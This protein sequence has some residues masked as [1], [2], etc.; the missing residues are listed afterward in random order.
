MTALIHGV[1]LACTLATALLPLGMT[2]GGARLAWL[3]W[4]L[5]WGILA[6]LTAWGLF[7]FDP[8]IL[9]LA[10]HFGG[11]I[12]LGLA[13]FL[14]LPQLHTWLGLTDFVSAIGTA[15]LTGAVIGG[16]YILIPLFLVPIAILAHLAVL[17]RV[18]AWGAQAQAA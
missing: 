9:R 3:A 13:L 17:D 11:Q 12:A 18:G 14:A 5:F 2:R 4:V 7:V 1:F 15:I 16:P 6:G 8:P 10:A